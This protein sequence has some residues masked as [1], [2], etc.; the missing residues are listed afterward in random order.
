MALKTI[1]QPKFRGFGSAHFLT[2]Q[3]DTL[4]F[5]VICGIGIGKAHVWSI[6]ID[7]SADAVVKV[8][9]FSLEESYILLE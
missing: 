6:D 4:S 5:R 9:V 8:T 2:Q 1:K 7:A 3:G